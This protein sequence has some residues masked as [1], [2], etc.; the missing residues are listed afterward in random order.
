MEDVNLNDIIIKMYSKNIYHYPNDPKS[1]NNFEN[2]ETLKE[3]K[4]DFESILPKYLSSKKPFYIP[5][6]YESN[7]MVSIITFYKISSL[8]VNLIALNNKKQANILLDKNLK[9]LNNLFNKFK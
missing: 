1:L 4:T 3:I 5:K 9:D 8:Y 7:V 6:E 2:N